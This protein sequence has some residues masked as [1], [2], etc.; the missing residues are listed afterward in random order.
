MH[1]PA[2]SRA[3]DTL[4]ACGARVRC[5]VG[6]WFLTGGVGGLIAGPIGALYSRW[7]KPGFFLLLGVMCA[8]D[9]VLVAL[10]AP[11]LHRHA[12]AACADDGH[13]KRKRDDATVKELDEV[14]A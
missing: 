9:G 14:G 13:S 5:Q 11:Q 8:A 6:I 2:S 3:S 4:T 12:M 1:A 10:V 7:P